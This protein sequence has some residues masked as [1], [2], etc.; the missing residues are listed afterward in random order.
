MLRCRGGSMRSV[1]SRC[2]VLVAIAFSFALTS[3]VSA[4]TVTTVSGKVSI[5]RGDGFV[6]IS[7]GT[8]AKPGD[9]VMA[10]LAGMAEI[11]YDDGCRQKVEPGSVVAVAQTPP[12]KTVTA[13]QDGGWATQTTLQTQP[14]IWPYVLGGAAVG[15]I[16]AVA[17]SLGG[18]SGSSG[19]SGGSGGDAGG[20]P[21][22]SP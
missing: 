13:S 5:N 16:A 2:C 1:R 14:N 19:V 7:S 10:G 9:R 15:G 17:V 4:A 21:P 6:Q 12:C 20:G 8:A 11:V 3:A 22:T 18:S